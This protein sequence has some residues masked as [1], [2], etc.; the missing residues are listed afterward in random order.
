M[1]PV[2][3]VQ[4]QIMQTRVRAGSE[5]IKTLSQSLYKNQYYVFDEIISNAYDADATLV[6][7]NLKADEL[8]ITDNG[9]GMSKDDIDNY[10]WL[11]YS[12]KKEDR[13][14]KRFKRHTIGKFGIGKLSMHV[15]CDTAVIT[16]VKKKVKITINLDFNKILSHKGLD[17]E[18][19]N[20]L[21]E[22]TTEESGTEI[23][24]L[25]LKRKIDSK[26]AM[27]RILQTMPLSPAFQIDFNGEILKA[28]NLIPG[29]VYNV[30]LNLPNVGKVSGKLIHSDR[31]LKEF[32][33][34][35]IKVCSR[36]VNADDPDIFDLMKNLTSPHSLVPRMYCVID[37][38]GL[39]D[40]ILA[41]RNG[42]QEDHPKFQELKK[43]MLTEIR[44]ITKD[45]QE[46]S[47]LEDMKF[48][49]DLLDDVARQQIP[50]MLKGVQLPEDWLAKTT[51]RTDA[52]KIKGAIAKAK[53]EIEQKEKDNS[54]N[55]PQNKVKQGEQTI[56]IG[57]RKFKFRLAALGKQNYECVLDNSEEC[58][59]VNIDH[60]QYNLSRT[61]GSL[62]QHYRRVVCFEL[63]RAISGESATELCKSYQDMMCQDI[64]LE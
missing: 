48:E 34:V 8:S 23:K 57:R 35:Y 61:E 21:V 29:K 62:P 60:T 12:G 15:L 58:F 49:Q 31:P 44:K 24:L 9:V 3:A 20:V 36:V 33:G 7:I 38:D 19:I 56:K 30:E 1:T 32:A 13:R 11:G 17:E 26:F 64:K 59:Y 27:R 50:E 51:S 4:G 37:A 18:K 2:K 28:E 55:D 52:E 25:D 53:R 43:A 6:K 54:K 46:N 42:F 45:I 47:A 40:I 5:L 22:P 39:D 41:T 14:S 16:S 63:A 10:L